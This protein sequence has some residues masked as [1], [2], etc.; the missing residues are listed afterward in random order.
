[1][2]NLVVQLLIL[3]GII[4]VAVVV[5]GEKINKPLPTQKKMNSQV[6]PYFMCETGKPT[7]WCISPEYNKGIEPWI[8]LNLTK[9]A[10]PWNYYFDFHIFDVVEINDQTQIIVLV[11]YALIKWYEPR[12]NIN[13]TSIRWKNRAIQIEGESYLSVPIDDMGY[14]WIPDPEVYWIKRYQS[15]TILRPAANLRISRNK[16][17]RYMTR[18]E[19]ALTCQMNFENYPFDSQICPFRIGS[20]NDPHQIVN[21]TSKFTYYTELQR[22]QQYTITVS[23][24][25]PEEHILSFGGHLWA[26]CGFNIVLKR[27]KLQIFFHMY[28]PSM[29]LVIV[30]WV[31]FLVDPDIV[32][33]R[34]G[35]IVTIFLVLVNIFIGVQRD[36]PK[37]T[38]L[39]AAD[40]FLVVCFVEVFATFIEYSLVLYGFGKERKPSQSPSKTSIKELRSA[41]NTNQEPCQLDVTS[42]NPVNGWMKAFKKLKP[43]NRRNILD[44][45]SL[46]LFPTSFIT[47]IVVYTYQYL[48]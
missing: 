22:T 26:T 14:F 36:T 24:L 13:E 10:L 43:Q 17:F 4:L 42:R 9:S 33:G 19:V 3:L 44:T 6:N 21:C 38:G 16:L 23:D 27:K 31:S 7:A 11:M 20:F 45:T 47:F 39:H 40:V 8:D 32:P 1:M 2:L 5:G 37:S 30:S 29:L 25:L 41:H 28:L 35:L 48:K 15:Q 12:I 34:L 46:F 18:V